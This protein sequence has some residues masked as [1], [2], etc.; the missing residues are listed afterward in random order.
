MEPSTGNKIGNWKILLAVV[1]FFFAGLVWSEIIFNPP[2][3]NPEIYFLDVGQG[4]SEL[5]VLPGNVKVLIDGGPNGKTL[6]NLSAVL[7]KFDR[8]IDLVV[9]THPDADHFAGLIDV[10]RRYDIGTFISSGEAKDT[11]TFREF[12]KALGENKI[13]RIVL[14]EG[15]AIKYGGD[16]FKILSPARNFEITKNSNG[17]ALVIKY[18]S[19]NGEKA[20]FTADIDFAAENA[21]MKKYD[22]KSDILKIAHH[23]SKYSSGG[24][25]LEKVDPAISVVEVGKNSYGHPNIGVLDRLAA[26]NSKIFRTDKNGIVKLTLGVSLIDI[27]T[28]K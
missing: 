8:H 6:D 3:G 10:V 18:I 19:A 13:P 4:D 17:D 16:E 23:G 26:L 24:N 25:F 15:D 7:P 5:V 9:M 28:Q 20:L 14:A 1:L 2:A 27:F 22:L 21:L 11:A 12:D